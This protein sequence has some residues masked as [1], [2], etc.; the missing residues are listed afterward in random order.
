MSQFPRV[1]II[2]EQGGWENWEVVQIESFKCETSQDLC[3]RERE[4][5]DQLKPT[6]NNRRPKITVAERKEE[7]RALPR[8]GERQTQNGIERFKRHGER[9][10]Q[11]GSE[12]HARRGRWQI[13][14]GIER[15]KRDGRQSELC[16]STA[17]RKSHKVVLRHINGPR[18]A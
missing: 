7:D 2:R 8:R 17:I 10:T 3:Q 4:V 6:L 11:N 13:Q 18:S 15:N 12:K 14:N 9:Q 1:Q 16:V 5:F